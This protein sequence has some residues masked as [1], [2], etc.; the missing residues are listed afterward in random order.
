MLDQKIKKY[1]GLE[2]QVCAVWV[3]GI[4][5]WEACPIGL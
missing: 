1:P 3:I 4:E 2:R 5:A